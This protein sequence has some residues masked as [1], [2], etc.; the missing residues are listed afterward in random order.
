M[1]HLYAERDLLAA[2]ESEAG[3]DYVT[4]PDGFPVLQFGSEA[5]VKSPYQLVLTDNLQDFVVAAYVKPKTSSGGWVFSVV[6]SLDTVV[7]LGLLLEPTASGDDWNATLFYTDY[8]QDIT[9]KRLSSFQFPFSK[10]W[11]R[12]MF[13]IMHD[14]VDFYYNCVLNNTDWV[15]KQPRKLVFDSA[16]TVYVGQAG[17]KLKKKFET[18]SACLGTDLRKSCQCCQLCNCD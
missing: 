6:N 13:R 15:K 1:H 14:H 2:I 12:L 11:H 5:D 4:G 3:V 17:P 9:S 10:K 8:R 16:S 18:R 7:Q